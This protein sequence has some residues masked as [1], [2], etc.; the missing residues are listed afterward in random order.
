MTDEQDFE[1]FFKG[2]RIG[3][4]AAYTDMFYLVLDMKTEDDENINKLLEVLRQRVISADSEVKHE[5][6]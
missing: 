3:R 2:V 6:P 4:K 1:W 5:L